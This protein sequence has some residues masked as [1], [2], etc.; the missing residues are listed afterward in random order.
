MTEITHAI[1]AGEL[2]EL[3]LAWDASAC[4][5]EHPDRSVGETRGY[6][7]GIPR[8][9]GGDLGFLSLTPRQV[10]DVLAENFGPPSLAARD[11]DYRRTWVRGRIAEWGEA[12]LDRLP[13][14]SD[15]REDAA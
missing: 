15:E 4:R 9:L 8:F 5:W 1:D 12:A 6:W 10:E 13:P 14:P 2:G 7:T 3:V 11:T